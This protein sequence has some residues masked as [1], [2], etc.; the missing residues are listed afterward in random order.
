MDIVAIAVTALISTVV[1]A[2]VGAAVSS[3]KRAGQRHVDK[4]E[5]EKAEE[6]AMKLGIRALLWRELKTIHADAVGNGGMD[7]EMR[8]HLE[9]VY[10][11]D[12]RPGGGG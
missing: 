1:G 4:T 12:H 5:A 9:G 8:R 10:S 3:I 6:L 11:A 2:A 7:I